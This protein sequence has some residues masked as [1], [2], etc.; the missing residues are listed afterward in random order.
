MGG[1]YDRPHPYGR[2]LRI[3]G[4]QEPC[5]LSV[6]EDVPDIEF[7][8][9]ALVADSF[10]H[11]QAAD[12]ACW[13]EVFTAPSGLAA[14]ATAV[15]AD[16]LLRRA[17]A[18]LPVRLVYPDGTVVG[19]GDAT[20][21]VLLIH[22]PDRLAR[23]MGRH[24]LIGFGESYMAGEWESTDLVGLLT[25]LTPALDETVPRGLRRLASYAL[26]AQPRSL[27]ASREQVLRSLAAHYD[28]VSSDLFIEFLDETM[29]YSSAIFDRLPASWSDL[30][31]AQRNKIDRLLDAAGV[32]PGTRLLEI[33]PGWGELCIRAAARGAEVRSVTPSG[34]QGWLARQRVIAAGQSGR[35][36]IEVCDYRD[37]DGSYD[38][39]ISVEMIEAVGNHSWPD[40]L[41]TIG[42][43]VEPGGKVVIQAIARPQPQLPAGRDRRT[44]T[45]K[46]IF[47][48]GATPAAKAVLDA[49]QRQAG[50]TLL[51]MVSLRPHYA[52]TLRLWRE[53]FLQRRKTLA[54][55]G[56]DDVFARMW[57]YYLADREAGFRSGNLNV[58]QWTLANQAVP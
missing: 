13:P 44:W 22:E 15:I 29:T 49:A 31:Q 36:H 35:A 7:D 4:V 28:D 19:G 24:G 26:A 21:P 27:R 1:R 52:E 57:E 14:A 18:A 8:R 37:I 38:A 6:V 5:H 9:P 56:F 45:Q 3:H 25:V 46:Y 47:P 39:V 55:I 30:A 42:R 20:A 23:R 17:A 12:S 2:P 32:G 58:Y 34:R 54:H 43:L 10:R 41:R 50:L 16:R 48:G 33:G 51:D 53:R 40:V 11:P